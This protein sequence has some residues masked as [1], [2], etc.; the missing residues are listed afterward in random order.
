[1]RKSFV[2]WAL[3]SILL[4]S[5][6]TLTKTAR[7][8]D[9][10]SS[11]QSVTVADLKVSDRI[12]YTMDPV[13]KEIRRGGVENVKRAVEAE[14]L[15]KKGGN[16]DVLL[17]P[18]YV[19]VK[20]RSLLGSKI[21][22]V[23]VSGRPAYYVNFRALND[24]VWSNPYFRGVG[25]MGTRKLST[26]KVKDKA[27]AIADYYKG[28]V[29][30]TGFTSYFDIYGG[31]YDVNDEWDEVHSGFVGGT[32]SFGCQLTPQVY[33][34]VGAGVT[35]LA[36]EIEAGFIPVFAHGRYYLSESKNSLFVD[37]K[38]GSSLKGWDC[39]DLEPGFYFSPSIGYSFNHFEIALQY[40]HQ[41]FSAEDYDYSEGGYYD[42]DFKA[43]HWGLS[44]GW[45]F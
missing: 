29:R 16:A 43:N 37:C 10:S 44:L 26:V 27:V 2:F 12:T 6:E 8:A 18:Q 17:E 25:A 7:T 5:C 21:T 28:D 34:G 11:L 42:R 1:M 14:A 9:V 40:M 20:K 35:Y 39:Y 30:R 41:G 33:L 13:K 23:T 32:L 45:R 38:L 15:E 19:F 31:Y 24:S 22:S 3:L 4:S 36:D